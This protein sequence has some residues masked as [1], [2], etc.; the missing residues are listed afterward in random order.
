M[1]VPKTLK[2]SVLHFLLSSLGLLSLLFSKQ[3]SLMHLALETGA[4]TKARLPVEI[5]REIATG[6]GVTTNRQGHGEKPSQTN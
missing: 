4:H 3:L 6:C 2:I 1:N 5:L